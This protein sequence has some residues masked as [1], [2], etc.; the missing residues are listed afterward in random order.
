MSH[1]REKEREKEN[2]RS[3]RDKTHTAFSFAEYSLFDRALLQKR[4]IILHSHTQ[5]HGSRRCAV[6]MNELCH[7]YEEDVTRM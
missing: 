2:M 3:K 5:L 7:V 1:E 6:Y 4:L